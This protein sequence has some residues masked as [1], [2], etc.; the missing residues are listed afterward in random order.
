MMS[1]KQKGAGRS[2]LKSTTADSSAMATRANPLTPRE[3]EE[4]DGESPAGNVAED[5]ANIFTVLKQISGELQS[6]GEIRKTTSSMEEK[7][8]SLV[9]RINDVEGRLGF[10]EESDSHL[11]ANPPATKT[12]LESLREKVDDMEDRNRRNNLRF[13]G[14]PEGC[15]A[16]DVIAFL[17]G[18][19]PEM[20]GIT[21]SSKGWLIERAHRIGPRIAEDRRNGRTL[22]AK[23]MRSG[24]RDRILRAS[25]EKGEIRWNGKR[26]MI[27]PDFSRGTLAKRDAFR[28]CKKMLHQRG[29]KF[30]LQYPATL[31]IDT[32]EGPRRFDNP[33]KAMD[34]IRNELSDST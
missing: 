31:R 33:R 5:I 13:V 14:I 15:E 18:A 20:L 19:L 16:G 27:F 32:K 11:K 3:E 22:I 10:L 4:E 34:F 9:T 30:A 12:E 29:I 7:L 24:D 1:G 8:T 17:E 28:E 6:L 26:V 2:N 25:Q 23:F 21:F